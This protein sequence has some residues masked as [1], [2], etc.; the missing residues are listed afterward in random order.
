MKKFLKVTAALI[1]LGILTLVIMAWASNEELPQGHAGPEADALALKMLQAL[2][3][4]AYK[5]TQFLEWSYQGGK[6]QYA[7]DKNNGLVSVKW[8]EVQVNLN[9]NRPQESKVFQN[10]VPVS[11][12]KKQKVD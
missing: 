12:E 10:N 9:L 1:L 4:E 8:D 3:V 7:W 5:N 11:K 2:N 6:N